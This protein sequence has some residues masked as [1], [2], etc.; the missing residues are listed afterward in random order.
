MFSVRHLCGEIEGRTD[1]YMGRTA[2]LTV[3]GHGPHYARALCKPCYMRALQDGSF[4]TH[5]R[6]PLKEDDLSHP[7]TSR[8]QALLEDIEAGAVRSLADAHRVGYTS[9]SLEKALTRMKRYSLSRLLRRRMNED[10]A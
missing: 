4:S 3:C 7:L 8:E 5:L 6:L 10:H 9:K 1:R 2:A